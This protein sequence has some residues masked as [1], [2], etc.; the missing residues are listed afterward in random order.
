MELV[1]KCWKNQFMYDFHRGI[2][3]TVAN[4]G[5]FHIYPVRESDM[6]CISGI[7]LAKLC[8]KLVI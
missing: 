5:F 3:L 1:R 2:W 7:T 4:L 6:V 8:S